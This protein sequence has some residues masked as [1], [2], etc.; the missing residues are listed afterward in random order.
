MA[1]SN[2]KSD[3]GFL[4]LIFGAV[5]GLV[6]QLISGTQRRRDA[7][8]DLSSFLR[9]RV[10]QGTTQEELIQYCIDDASKQFGRSLTASEKEEIRGVVIKELQ[11]IS[12]EDSNQTAVKK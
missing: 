11:Q 3:F 9:D 8:T 10:K 1:N 2:K 12:E 7:L 5:F 4:A 6:Y